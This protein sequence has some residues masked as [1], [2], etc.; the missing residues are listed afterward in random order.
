MSRS[1]DARRLAPSGTFTS[2]PSQDRTDPHLCGQRHL[3]QGPP[4]DGVVAGQLYLDHVDADGVER[5]QVG[6]KIA[7]RVRFDESESSSERAGAP[8]DASER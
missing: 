4:D 6:D 8:G 1:P 5:H 2:G 7:C 3:S